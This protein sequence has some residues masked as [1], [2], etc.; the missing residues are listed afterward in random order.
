[1]RYRLTPKNRTLISVCELEE[2]IYILIKLISVRNTF[3]MTAGAAFAALINLQNLA[4]RTRSWE[5]MLLS[6]M[7]R[8]AA[9]LPQF[10]YSYR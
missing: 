5:K 7:H 3:W 9:K 2:K 1:M 4:R 8:V 10:L 6:A